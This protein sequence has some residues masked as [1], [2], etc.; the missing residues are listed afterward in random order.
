MAC[1]VQRP[2]LFRGNNKNVLEIP[3]VVEKIDQFSN[4][5]PHHYVCRLLTFYEDNVEVSTVCTGMGGTIVNCE[6]QKERAREREG[7]RGR[8]RG[9]A[10]VS[11]CCLGAIV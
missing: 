6:H 1:V 4:L 5:P 8:G 7:E 2:A 11:G 10:A 3:V 9:G